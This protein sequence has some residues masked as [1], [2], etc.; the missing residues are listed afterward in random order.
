MSGVGGERAYVYV[1]L[2]SGRRFYVGIGKSGDLRFMPVRLGEHKP[3]GAQMTGV[4]FYDIGPWCAKANPEA[5]IA[6]NYA[7]EQYLADQLCRQGLE[8]VAPCRACARAGRRRASTVSGC[9]DHTNGGSS[10][11]PSTIGV[12]KWGPLVS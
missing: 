7:C 9:L 2:Y 8:P 10:F 5:V 3:A 1:G 6:H 4:R 11:L 12:R